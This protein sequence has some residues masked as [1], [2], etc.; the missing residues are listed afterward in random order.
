MTKYL[1]IT[2]F[3]HTINQ[4]IAVSFASKVGR[5]LKGSHWLRLTR[6]N[7]WPTETTTKRHLQEPSVRINSKNNCKKI[8]NENFVSPGNFSSKLNCKNIK[9]RNK[10]NF[11]GLFFK[12][13]S[14]NSIILTQNTKTFD[15][16]N[17]CLG[18]SA[19]HLPLHSL[20]L[21]IGIKITWGR[22]VA[23][24]NTHLFFRSF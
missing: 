24:Q 1:W 12:F 16:L 7:H 19:S 10:Y 11:F 3:S 15:F 8:W 20:W 13:S 14:R 17:V 9:N 21:H 6:E 18:W 23:G 4:Q 22:A 2:S 5:I